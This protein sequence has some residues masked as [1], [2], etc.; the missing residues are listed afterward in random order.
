MPARTVKMRD[1]QRIVR[2]YNCSIRKTTKEWEVIDNIDGQWV[3]GFGTVSGREIKEPYGK[4]FLKLM[5][6]KRAR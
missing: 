2:S 6:D 1:F 5:T 4:N 3:C